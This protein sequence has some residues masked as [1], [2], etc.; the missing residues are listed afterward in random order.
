[1]TDTKAL[2]ISSLVRRGIRPINVLAHNAAIA[3]GLSNKN[4]RGNVA[5]QTNKIKTSQ[6]LDALRATRRAKLPPE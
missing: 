2:A 4:Q 5:Q 1:M 6:D 3:L